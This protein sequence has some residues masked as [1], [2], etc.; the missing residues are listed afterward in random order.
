MAP[1]C[2][3]RSCWCSRWPLLDIGPNWAG[4]NQLLKG[5]TTLISLP[6]KG[7]PILQEPSRVL[8]HQ[9]LSGAFLGAG[10]LL[11]ICHNFHFSFSWAA[12]WPSCIFISSWSN[13]DGL[14]ANLVLLNSIIYVHLSSNGTVSTSG[15]WAL[16]CL[17]VRV[18]LITSIRVNLYIRPCI[19]VCAFF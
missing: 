6:T 1:Q 5:T 10:L 2:I 3:S 13:L 11:R 12:W 9:R 17:W 18:M 15:H 16:C 19:F 8:L 14:T 4:Q 7:D